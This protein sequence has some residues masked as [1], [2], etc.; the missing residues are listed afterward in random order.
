MMARRLATDAKIVLERA[1]Y[2]V[3]G[4]QRDLFAR[5]RNAIVMRLPITG[6]TVDNDEVVKLLNARGYDAYGYRK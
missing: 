3:S 5:E 6:G 2:Q 4:E 1:G